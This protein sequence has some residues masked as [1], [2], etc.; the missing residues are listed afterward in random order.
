MSFL[1]PGD[2]RS[3]EGRT[4]KLPRTGGYECANCQGYG[5]WNLRPDAYGPDRHFVGVCNVCE[6]Y[7]YHYGCQH[8]WGHIEQLSKTYR[9][10]K[11]SLCGAEKFID[12]GD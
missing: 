9:K 4:K 6:G 10:E 2:P 12:S 11:C 5:E 1:N 7:G 3:F 8:K